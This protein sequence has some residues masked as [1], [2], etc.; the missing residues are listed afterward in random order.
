MTDTTTNAS[1]TE[2]ADVLDAAADF[3]ETYGWRQGDLGGTSA[4]PAACAAGAIRKTRPGDGKDLHRSLD[5]QVHAITTL[6]E[7]LRNNIASRLWAQIVEHADPDFAE[8]QNLQR[9]VWS[10]N[11]LDGQT[12]DNV[13]ATLRQAAQHARDTHVVAR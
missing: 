4:E 2:S 5:L 10:W 3:I 9:A 8:F 12:A 13:I 1:N 6:G 11:D 7:Y